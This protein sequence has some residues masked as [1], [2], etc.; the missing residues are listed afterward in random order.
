MQKEMFTPLFVLLTASL[1]LFAC[2]DDKQANFD[3]PEVKTA[4]ILQITQYSAKSGGI[5]LDNG[6]LPVNSRGVIWGT[7]ENLSIEDEDVSYT[8]DSL[9]LGEFKSS[10]SNLEPG[11]TYSVRAYATNEEGTSYG[12]EYQTTVIR[13]HDEKQVGYSVRCIKDVN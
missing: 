3:P 7:N 10:I 12:E 1:L 11:T 4:E 6:G 2:N 13:H 5:V 8:N 9:G